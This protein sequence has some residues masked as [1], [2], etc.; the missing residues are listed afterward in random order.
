MTD[1]LVGSFFAMFATLISL[2]TIRYI[3]VAHVG[4]SVTKFIFG[5]VLWSI[6]MTFV[7]RNRVTRISAEKR[8]FS[9]SNIIPIGKKIYS[10]GDS[11]RIVITRHYS[12]PLSLSAWYEIYLANEN[13]NLPIYASNTQKGAQ[14]IANYLSKGFT[15]YGIDHTIDH[16]EVPMK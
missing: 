15:A 3:E 16:T 10:L 8:E 6:S 9:R 1:Y 5:L 12:G 4:E 11:P 14:Q 7:I 13:I 2:W